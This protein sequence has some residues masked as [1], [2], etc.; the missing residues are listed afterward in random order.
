MRRLTNTEIEAAMTA[1]MGEEIGFT[2]GFPPEERQGGFENNASVL[3]F[4]PTLSER[5]FEAAERAG[6]RVASNPGAFAD[7]AES[8]RN[9]ACASTLIGAFA[10]R[11]W[12][13]PVEPDE[14]ARLM[15]AYEL[16]AEQEGFELGVSL[17]VQATL[18]SLPFYYLV[19]DGTAIAKPG[20][21]AL[22]G[23]QRASRLAF[24]LWRAPPDEALL[25]A[26]ADGRLDTTE[27]VV[28]QAERMLDAPRALD[29]LEEF[30]RQW[31]E[32][33]RVA[34]VNKDPERYPDWDDELPSKMLS[35][36]ELFVREASYVDDSVEA[37]LTARYS[38]QDEVL[39]RFYADGSSPE[40]TGF[41]RLQLPPR[42][43]GLLAR[44][45]FL[46]MEGFDQT[47]PVLRGLFIRE[48]MLCGELPPPPEFVD[49]VP[50]EPS[51]NDTTRSRVEA[52]A[53][54][55]QCRGCHQFMDPIGFGLER[56]DATGQWRTTEAGLPIDDRGEVVATDL[57]TFQGAAE[58]GADLAGS[59]FFR[60][61]FVRKW[62]R[63]ALG[64][65]ETDQDLSTLRALFDVVATTGSYRALRLALVQT[66]QFLYR[67]TEDS[68]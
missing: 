37:L 25:A 26:A 35:E 2:D 50:S 6:Q 5:A 64:R 67:R 63:F 56:Y 28:A 10:R 9:A 60:A 31:L 13:R 12:R 65:L 21:L 39:R 8:T 4:P 40:A 27:G 24:F 16:G 43:A 17:A 15:S 44:G 22:D 51:D 19:E 30:H 7:C 38:F 57:G 36:L 11:A 53:S 41:D 48:K 46:I 23:Y 42:R 66:D 14:L 55:P 68:Q 62:F 1:L 54:D 49:N 33:D 58:L 59:A 29:A 47:S 20:W 34:Q 61:C 32:L 18:L 52:H 3:T 45:G